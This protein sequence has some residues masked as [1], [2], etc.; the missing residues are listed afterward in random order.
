MDLLPPAG[1]PR[2]LQQPIRRWDECAS[3]I[4]ETYR[5]TDGRPR[6]QTRHLSEH[7][8]SAYRSRPLIRS[9]TVAALLIDLEVAPIP[10]SPNVLDE[11]SP[12]EAG[13]Q[14]LHYRPDFTDRSVPTKDGRTQR[15]PTLQA[16]F[17][18]LPT[19]INGRV[20]R[21]PQEDRLWHL[22]TMPT[23][24]VLL[25]CMKSHENRL[26]IDIRIVRLLTNMHEDAIDILQ[27][28]HSRSNWRST[29]C[30]MP[31]WR[32]YSTSACAS[33]LTITSKLLHVRSALATDTLTHC[34]GSIPSAMPVI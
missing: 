18:T 28:V 3:R 21:P 29:I 10:K 11:K 4:R 27:C 7:P 9:K 12:T 20:S 34:L 32:K 23:L 1:E 31:P 14:T 8:D 19:R 13:F 6:R 22:N 15:A 5:A 25:T 30:R 26:G 33:I 2:R 17:A 16:A 24:P